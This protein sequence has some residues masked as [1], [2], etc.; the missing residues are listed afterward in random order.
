MVAGPDLDEE[1]VDELPADYP[2]ARP[3]RFGGCM[4][5]GLGERVPCVFLT[6]RAN[7]LSDEIVGPLW[8]GE[9]PL[10]GRATCAL[11]VAAAGRHSS[12]EISKLTAFCETTCEEWSRRSIVK[13]LAGLGVDE[14]LLV[15][16]RGRQRFSRPRIHGF[17]VDRGGFTDLAELVAK[18][19]ERPKVNTAPG[20]VLTV[21]EVAREYAGRMTRPISPAARKRR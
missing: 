21:E 2:A 16:K 3:R 6:C 4:R 15:D 10:E 12:V 11:R 1:L 19:P 9:A 7:L 13:L 8:D 5:L 17:R 18:L 14:F 20:R